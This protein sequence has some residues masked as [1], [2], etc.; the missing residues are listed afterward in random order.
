MRALLMTLLVALW[1]SFGG[2]PA[3]A[4]I[5]QELG[6]DQAAIAA[7]RA[8]DLETAR[9]LWLETLSNEA[10][11]VASERARIAYNLGNSYLRENKALAAV[12]WFTA[13]LRLRPRDADTWANLELARLAAGLEAADRGDLGATVNRLLSSLTNSESSWLALLALLPLAGALAL[14]ALRGTR[15]SR[16]LSIVALLF[17]AL[18]LLPWCHHRLEAGR[19]PI[20]IVSEEPISIRAEPRSD[21]DRVAELKAGEIVQR[22][23]EL[24]GWT[25]VELSGRRRGWLRSEATFQLNR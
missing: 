8:G 22:V 21:A 19:D 7:Y 13:S 1:W 10:D 5:P 6:T 23:D 11:L 24:S 4:A 20:L 9:S 3:A 12:G 15:A 25:E 16:W 18:A 14:E 17:A 2:G